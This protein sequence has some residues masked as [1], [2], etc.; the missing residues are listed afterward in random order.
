MMNPD[1][2]VCLYPSFLT[3]CAILSMV[4]LCVLTHIEYIFKQVVLVVMATIHC[5][6]LLVIVKSTFEQHDQP[7][8]D[9]EYVNNN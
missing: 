4:S 9:D 5:I 2:E 8:Q 3:H 6:F 7:F 1:P